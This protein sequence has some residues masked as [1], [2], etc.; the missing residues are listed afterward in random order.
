MCI[1]DAQ[2]LKEIKKFWCFTMEYR[3]GEGKKMYY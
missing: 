2:T 1:Q 3:V